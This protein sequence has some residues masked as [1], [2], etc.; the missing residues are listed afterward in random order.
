MRWS[1]FKAALLTYRDTSEGAPPRVLVANEQTVSL[2]GS[3]LRAAPA[4]TSTAC[5]NSGLKRDASRMCEINL[6]Q[7]LSRP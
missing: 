7:E 1:E 4:G 3:S 6:L 5:I 2:S